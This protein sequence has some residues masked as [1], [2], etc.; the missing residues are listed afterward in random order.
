M[1]L[2][3]IQP[4]GTEKAPRVGERVC[5]VMLTHRTHDFDGFAKI[6]LPAT[7]CRMLVTETMRSAP[8]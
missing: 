1:S 2:P 4:R 5:R 7:V 3:G 8:M 6:N